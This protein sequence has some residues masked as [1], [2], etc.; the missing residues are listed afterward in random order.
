MPPGRL[1]I[2][3]PVISSPGELTSSVI[4]AT[5]LMSLINEQQSS[6]TVDTRHEQAKQK[7]VLMKKKREHSEEHFQ[8]I[9][10]V[11]TSSEKRK[12]ELTA[13]KGASN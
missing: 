7:H 10:S 9:S 8:K 3:N 5:P 13:E 12:L 2:Q 11:S 1:D 6:L 4:L